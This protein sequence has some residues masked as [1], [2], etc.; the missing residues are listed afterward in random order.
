MVSCIDLVALYGEK[1]CV[2]IE[3]SAGSRSTDP[4]LAQ[5]AESLVKELTGGRA[6]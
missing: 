3:S 1:Y 5:L 6:A 2:E 4:W